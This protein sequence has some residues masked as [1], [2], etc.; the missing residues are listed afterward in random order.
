MSNISQHHGVCTSFI[1]HRAWGSI[2]SKHLTPTHQLSRRAC[3]ITHSIFLPLSSYSTNPVKKTHREEALLSLRVSAVWTHPG[4]RHN[5]SEVLCLLMAHVGTHTPHIKSH[6]YPPVY[7]EQLL[8]T[9]LRL[10]ACNRHLFAFKSMIQR[11]NESL[12]KGELKNP[13][14]SKFQLQPRA[15][16]SVCPPHN[17]M[18]SFKKPAC[19][20]CFCSTILSAD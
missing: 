14:T 7:T 11:K 12:S 2:W 1:L 15:V 5:R 16:T 9:G 3:L 8:L 13:K 19:N 18:F 4:P 6:N 10:G 17:P 20:R